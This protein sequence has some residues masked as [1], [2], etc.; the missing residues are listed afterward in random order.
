MVVPHDIA[1]KAT[2]D[3]YLLKTKRYP[4]EA[5]EERDSSAGNIQ[6]EQRLDSEPSKHSLSYHNMRIRAMRFLNSPVASKRVAPI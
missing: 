3:T 6:I 2:Q 1:R 5:D 4:M